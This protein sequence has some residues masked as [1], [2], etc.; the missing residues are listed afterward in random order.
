MCGIAG[1]RRFGKTPIAGEEIVL[2]L[3]A[4]EHRGQH[5]TGMALVD[6]NGIKILK[7]PLPAWKFTKSE[8]FKKFID[9]TLNE[10][11]YIALLHTRWATTS[12]PEFNQN[13]HPM[14]DGDCALVHNGSLNNGTYIVNND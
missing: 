8:E 11:T 6:P 7:A 4:L 3:C 13:N 12:N 2:L 1:I 5:A 14:W 10:Q 9:E